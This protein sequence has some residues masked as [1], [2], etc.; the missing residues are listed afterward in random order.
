MTRLAEDRPDQR[1]LRLRG[2]PTACRP[3]RLI[4]GLHAGSEQSDRMRF[5][6]FLLMSDFDGAP[7]HQLLDHAV[8]HAV[9]AEEHGFNTI[10][11]SEHHFGGEGIDIQ[12]NP[13]LMSSHLARYTTRL[14]VGLGAAILPEWH[15]LR[16][17]E[18]IA[19][20]DHS[21]GGRVEVAVAK[22]ITN[23]EISNLSHFDVDRRFAKGN[24]AIFL[25]TLSILRDAWTK[26]PFTHSGA[27]YRFPR[28][29]VQD[30]Y[31]AWWPRNE[32][33]RGEA[34]DYVGMSVV[35]KPFQQPHPPLS[36]VGDSKATFTTAADYDLKPIT[37]LLSG[38]ALV[39]NLELYRDLRIAKGDDVELGQDTGLMR[40][41]FIAPSAEQ[42]R[43]LVEPAVELLYRDY[44]G[45]LRGR[46]IYAQPGETISAADLAKPWYDFLNDRGHLLVGTASE[47]T[48]RIK[49]LE[50]TIGLNQLLVY[51]WL[52]GMQPEV[53]AESLRLFGQHVVPNFS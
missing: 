4:A 47:V 40:V 16:L 23:R 26:D 24:E 48:E 22:G 27:Y 2:L 32:G 44:L 34:G 30:S 12:P 52:H 18:D 28:P 38:D 20:L 49:E 43:E 39:Q 19:F 9:I 15:P 53:A 11:S 13:I 21:T 7:Y 36:I 37:W 35:P 8:S 5:D 33:W 10:W 17:A 25:E 1:D 50:S 6:Y 29:G 51:S 45:G 3:M 46:E 14:R 42:A 31:A 41:C